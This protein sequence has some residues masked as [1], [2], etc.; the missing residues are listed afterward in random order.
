MAI[1]EQ[2]IKDIL[3]F[4]STRT[5]TL[6]ILDSL[7]NVKHWVLTEEGKYN[8]NVI[9]IKFGNYEKSIELSDVPQ[10][11]LE[12]GN[13]NFI[14]RMVLSFKS[15]TKAPERTTN[16]YNK[17]SKRIINEYGDVKLNY[18][19][20]SV[21]YDMQ[22]Q[23]VIQARGLNEAFQIVEQILPLFR[24]TYPISIREYPLFEEKTETLLGIS[25]PEFDILTEFGPEDINIIN[26]TFDLN[27]RTNL[28]MPLQLTGPIE[29]VQMMIY[30]WEQQDYKESQLASHYEFEVCKY[31]YKIYNNSIHRSYAPEKIMN[32]EP[33][34]IPEI[35]LCSPEFR[36]T[37]S[38]ED[39]IDILTEDG[40]KIITEEEII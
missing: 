10:D 2:N 19:F 39:Y 13:F 8:E 28:Y 6:A 24:P 35:P 22:F 27:I 26:I 34:P 5:V 16:K 32:A 4:N 25:D 33:T 11:I 9:P 18:G 21:P 40:V 29:T 30:L 36:T 1:L 14:P 20:N 7:N 17:I 37:I 31:N 38:G 15:M 12:S 3:F 23:L